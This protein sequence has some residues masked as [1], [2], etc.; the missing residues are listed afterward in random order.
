M[1]DRETEQMLSAIQLELR[2][3]L[4]MR[5]LVKEAAR[6]ALKSLRDQR[7]RQSL[8]NDNKASHRH[9]KETEIKT[10]KVS[11][12]SEVYIGSN[13]QPAQEV[14]NSRSENIGARKAR[15]TYIAVATDRALWKRAD[16]RCEFIEPTSDCRCCETRYLQ[17]E[18][19]TP[20]ALGGSNQL[21]NLELLCP[22][23]NRYRALNVF[24]AEKMKS[25]VA[26]LR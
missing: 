3:T 19:V 5:E 10:P 23:H 12:E 1:I 26:A 4:G 13:A 21:E 6:L 2:R 7:Q 20:R 25:H 14:A 22:A 24:G 8:P 11:N 18:H 15:S 17:R 9:V 16:G